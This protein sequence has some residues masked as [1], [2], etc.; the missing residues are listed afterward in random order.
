M[1]RSSALLLAK[2][3]KFI[4]LQRETQRTRQ[5]ILPKLQAHRKRAKERENAPQRGTG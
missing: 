5:P 4:T 2:Q 1:K 3:K